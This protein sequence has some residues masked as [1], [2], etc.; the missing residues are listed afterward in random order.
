[1]ASLLEEVKVA[2]RVTSTKTDAEV[3]AWISAAK[4]DMARIGVDPAKL[5]DSSM[6]PLCKAAV[7][8]YVKGMYGFDNSEAPRFLESYRMVVADLANSPT[9]YRGEP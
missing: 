5:D 7:L 4:T 9:Q 8:L 6:D 1:M 2:L 3:S